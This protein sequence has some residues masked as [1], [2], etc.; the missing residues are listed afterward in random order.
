[1]ATDRSL[2][3]SSISVQQQIGRF[4]HT[5][6]RA[7][8]LNEKKQKKLDALKKKLRQRQAKAVLVDNPHG[9]PRKFAILIG[10]HKAIKNIKDSRQF[11]YAGHTVRF[12]SFGQANHGLWIN[13]SWI[14]PENVNLSADKIVYT[15]TGSL[16]EQDGG[17]VI[18]GQMNFLSLSGL[19]IHN[20]KG[21]YAILLRP[22]A[23]TYSIAVSAN[24][25]AV[26]SSGK[27]ELTWDVTSASWKNATWEADAGLLAFDTVSND[28][29]VEPMQVVELGI[30]DNKS[31]SPS[32]PPAFDF[33]LPAK[34]SPGQYVAIFQENTDMTSYLIVR[35]LDPAVIPPPSSKRALNAV[36]SLFPLLL[37]IDFDSMGDT[38]VGAYADA[39]QNV[40]A[41]KG[42]H[43]PSMILSQRSFITSA[44][45]SS[46]TLPESIDKPISVTAHSGF[47]SVEPIRGPFPTLSSPFSNLNL[48]GL[49][50]LSPMRQDA[51]GQ[52]YDA[53]TKVILKD[54]E[55]GILNFMDEELYHTFV[56]GP[57]PDL[58]PEIR[59]V[60][61]CDPLKNA[62]FYNSLQV[63][64]LV[65]SLSTSSLPAARHLNGVRA[66]KVL[67]E[68]PANDAVY[69]AQ[70]TL[71]YAFRWKQMYPVMQAY[72]DDQEGNDY[73]A[74]IS[75]AARVLKEQL[76][77]RVKGIPDITG[78][79]A[80]DLALGRKSIEELEKWALEHNLYWAFMLMYY[81]ETYYLPY[82]HVKMSSGRLAAEVTMELKTL[83][84]V[85]GLLEGNRINAA[86]KTFQAKFNE[87]IRA[88]TLT[89]VLPQYVDCQLN[90]VETVGLIDKIAASF[91][92]TYGAS[93]D[94]SVTAI[95][96]SLKGLITD[97]EIVNNFMRL[98]TSASLTSGYFRSW[99]RTVSDM[100]Q[101]CEHDDWYRQLANGEAPLN[102]FL[103]LVATASIILPSFIMKNTR[104]LTFTAPQLDSIMEAG[105]K[106]FVIASVKFV[107]G[108]LRMETFYDDIAPWATSSQ[109]LFGN[110][111][112][113]RSLGPQAL[114]VQDGFSRWLVG[115]TKDTLISDLPL[116]A[117]I[118]G[119][120]ASL[121]LARSLGSVVA[122]ANVALT[123][124]NHTTAPDP[125]KASRNDLVALSH[126]LAVIGAAAGFIS[127]GNVVSLE[128]S[129][130]AV[131]EMVSSV[132]GP[133][134]MA[135]AVAG[136]VVLIA[137]DFKP[138]HPPDPLR[139][140][141][142]SFVKK[143]GLYMENIAVDYFRVIPAGDMSTP[144]LEGVSLKQEA[145]CISIAHSQL[146]PL[147]GSV[148]LA[149]RFSNLLNTCLNLDTDAN[150]LTTIWTFATTTGAKLYLAVDE[151]G[152]VV[153]LPM[154]NK[155]QSN[156]EGNIT[157]VDPAVCTKQ[158]RQRQWEFVGLEKGSY[159]TIRDILYLK[160]STYTIRSAYTNRYLSVDKNGR[161]SLDSSTAKWVCEMQ[162]L[163]PGRLAYFPESWTLYTTSRDESIASIMDFP[164]SQ[165]LTW[166]I[167]PP[168]PLG[169][170]LETHLPDGGKIFILPGRTPTH[171]TLTTYTVSAS[172]V[173]DGRRFVRTATVDI[174]VRNPPGIL[175]GQSYVLAAASAP[176][177]IATAAICNILPKPNQ[178]GI[179]PTFPPVMRQVA[180][181]DTTDAA[182]AGAQ[183]DPVLFGYMQLPVVFEEH[184]VTQMVVNFLVRTISGPLYRGK[185]AAVGS[186]PAFDLDRIFTYPP[187]LDTVIQWDYM[188]YCEALVVKAIWNRNDFIHPW[189][190]L[191]KTNDYLATFTSVFYNSAAEFYAAFLGKHFGLRPSLD[192]AQAYK[193]KLL[194]SGWRSI[195]KAEQ[196][197]CT[198][199]HP[200]L[201]MYLHFVRCLACGMSESDIDD[202]YHN[203]TTVEPRLNPGGFADIT[204]TTW[205]R[206]KGWIFPNQFDGHQVDPTALDRTG[207]N[208]DNVN[209]V[210]AQRFIRDSRFSCDPDSSCFTG[211]TLVVMADDSLRRI[212]SIRKGDVVK[213]MKADT[214]EEQK[215]EVAFVST[216]RR[217][218]RFLF[219]IDG[220]QWLFTAT[221][222]FIQRQDRSFIV[223]FVDQNRANA[224]NPTW[225]AYPTGSLSDGTTY[226][227]SITQY[228]ANAARADDVLYD[229]LFDSTD[230]NDLGPHCYTA[231]DGHV[232]MLVASEVPAAHIFPPMTA[233]VAGLLSSAA[234][235]LDIVAHA[236]D[237]GQ[238]VLE[239]ARLLDS[240]GEEAYATISKK[241]ADD[242]D[243]LIPAM[244]DILSSSSDF[245]QEVADAVEMGIGAFGL[246]LLSDI[247]CGW[248]F[249]DN[250]ASRVRSVLVAQMLRL[251]DA[252]FASKFNNGG[253]LKILLNAI[254]FEISEKNITRNGP[255]LL[256]LICVADIGRPDNVTVPVSIAN[257]SG[258]V[259]VGRVALLDTQNPSFVTLWDEQY[260]SAVGSLMIRLCTV[261][262]A[263]LLAVE[264]WNLRASVTFGQVLGTIT[265][266]KIAQYCEGD[267][268]A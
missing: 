188:A 128:A 53:V 247:G 93:A 85:F 47:R 180:V 107:Q 164:G 75:A 182:I 265:G 175:L 230:A 256:S 78:D 237:D 232:S 203:L 258:D 126:S 252:D 161:P 181:G 235:V 192:L 10:G 11:L 200:S 111:E 86:G 29:P 151:T 248:R 52:W 240:C 49:L 177:K 170:H 179:F 102:L 262:K 99:P 101:L 65:A 267:T 12:P 238:E 8:V 201:E 166:S 150:G 178:Q 185:V 207:K 198:W 100:R 7:T 25:G 157:P 48:V 241:V 131:L 61:Y 136:L 103:L 189:I 69:Q 120:N 5:K 123:I 73:S 21:A 165:P 79:L 34:E 16:N 217:G 3:S 106:C 96:A 28:D 112:F 57:P 243:C 239:L 38:F 114:E 113:V 26:F 121:Y 210:L 147:K 44:L 176:R 208:W 13:N 36:S 39:K 46:D 254:P 234:S 227:H 45:L 244:S 205:R 191:Y 104:P 132:M 194:N 242:K 212:D 32:V 2:P 94:P 253:P 138:Q 193:G 72:L 43:T 199:A 156:P 77:D 225:L 264:G 197:Q 41:I 220:S 160:S 140:F 119:K 134:S 92:D 63:P 76:A 31:A 209:V 82:L 91:F 40:Y 66:A 125:L 159:V 142:E 148:K 56:G 255:C 143:A 149:K 222:P 187:Q 261:G 87:M 105:T 168:L 37:F 190:D 213:L 4:S 84:A 24:A 127:G 184:P 236:L 115:T 167:S 9:L 231:T 130:V 228:P 20:N 266:K 202:I 129:T 250:E 98:L 139:R 144:S 173:I 233:F 15:F 158:L 246:K 6:D 88:F 64:F 218:N 35:V 55:C 81:V 257:A 174:E 27:S 154:P 108:A 1:M 42:Q 141:I 97:K 95:L 145:A 263:G 58:S 19:L 51:D 54:F 219:S 162:P 172:I 133:L 183:V 116:I 214:G 169:L 110:E 74:Q 33:G 30:T 18:H 204:P 68:I 224:T 50:N 196:A 59:N 137:S 249:A 259:L 23:T 135:F 163:A 80:K 195:R 221:H 118:F 60:L 89:V 251:N 171:S 17:G 122:P 117:R 152:S 62:K 70:S 14:P 67:R 71:L 90:S 155:V 124:W 268:S 146:D 206:Y 229:L 223:S 186:Y 109:M 153:A 83:S 211:D 245:Q 216:P 215:R 22:Y 226:A 260:N